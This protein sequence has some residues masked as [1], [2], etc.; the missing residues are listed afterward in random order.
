MILLPEKESGTQIA[1][2]LLA[3]GESVLSYRADP[4]GHPIYLSLGTELEN[5]G[6]TGEASMQTTCLRQNKK[7]GGKECFVSVYITNLRAIV[8]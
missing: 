5:S 1:P 3:C 7:K 8:R 2:L 4:W 6:E